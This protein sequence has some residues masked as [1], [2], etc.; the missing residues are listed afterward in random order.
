MQN[1]VSGQQNYVQTNCRS[2][3][4]LEVFL[5]SVPIW[6]LHTC[7]H[8]VPMIF[9]QSTQRVTLYYFRRIYTI[10]LTTSFLPQWF[11]YPSILRMCRWYIFS[12]QRVGTTFA[13][14]TVRN[15]RRKY[16]F[17]QIDKWV[18]FSCFS[19]SFSCF[20]HIESLPVIS[21]FWT[22]FHVPI[23]PL[24]FLGAHPFSGSNLSQ[25]RLWWYNFSHMNSPSVWL[26]KM[27]IKWSTLFIKASPSNFDN[28]IIFIVLSLGVRLWLMLLMLVTLFIET[29]LNGFKTID[30]FIALSLEIG[31]EC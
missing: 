1:H 17:L 27:S 31:G 7:S 30:N 5:L 10:P 4:W 21:S 16:L 15:N 12:S 14:E 29:L 8:F 6:M 24:L 28:I 18:Y 11:V 3:V 9:P 20:E 23:W 2:V 25:I 19:F 22:F 13:G 26:G